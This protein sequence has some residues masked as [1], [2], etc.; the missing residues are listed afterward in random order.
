MEATARGNEPKTLQN[1]AYINIPDSADL[2]FL[3]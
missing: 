2:E 1:I 3:L